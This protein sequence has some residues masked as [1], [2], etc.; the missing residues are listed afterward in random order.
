MNNAVY[1]QGVEGRLRD[2]GIDPHA[3]LRAR[4]EYRHAIDLGEEIELAEFSAD[5]GWGIAFLSL[6][7]VKAVA[8]VEPI[9]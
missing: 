4:L 5:G 8:L 2:G 1:W 9:R 3:P 7:V 6:D